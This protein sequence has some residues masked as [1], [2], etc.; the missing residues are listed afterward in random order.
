MLPVLEF[1]YCVYRLCV[2]T[3]E[4]NWKLHVKKKEELE[5]HM[6]IKEMI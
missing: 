6:V 5:L 3:T 4:R 1:I 2:M